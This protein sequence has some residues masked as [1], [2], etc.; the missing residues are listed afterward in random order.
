MAR[1]RKITCVGFLCMPDGTTKPV[2]ELTP[3]EIKEWDKRASERLSRNMSEY[4]RL[5]PEYLELVEEISP[6]RKKAYYERFPEQ[7]R[8]RRTT[9]TAT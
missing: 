3:E 6:E 7:K 9:A 8:N 4:Y 1:G 2:E 5:H